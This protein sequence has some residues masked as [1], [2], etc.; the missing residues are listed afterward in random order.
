[1]V[2]KYLIEFLLGIGCF[3]IYTPLC[4]VRRIEKFNATHIIADVLILATVII[5]IVFAILRVNKLGWPY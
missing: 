4:W 3:V 5:I 2:N 1:M